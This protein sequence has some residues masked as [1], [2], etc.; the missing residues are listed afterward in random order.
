MH[1]IPGAPGQ[2]NSGKEK[3]MNYKTAASAISCGV[4]G[5]K[6]I[7]GTLEEAM[8]LVNVQTIDVEG[9]QVFFGLPINQ[10]PQTDPN[11]PNGIWVVPVGHLP[12]MPDA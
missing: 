9:R 2:T 11:N 8:K 5:A 4:P 1:L 10:I 3:T 6:T 12:Y 7:N